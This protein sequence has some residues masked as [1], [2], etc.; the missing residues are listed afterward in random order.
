MSDEIEITSQ[1]LQKIL[2]TALE[3]L[4]AGKI[5]KATADRITDSAKLVIGA[6]R[7]R[8]E[9]EPG[10]ERRKREVSLAVG[11]LREAEEKL[12]RLS[13]PTVSSAA[14]PFETR[15]FVDVFDSAYVKSQA[16]EGRKLIRNRYDV[17]RGRQGGAGIVCAPRTGVAIRVRV[18]VP[19]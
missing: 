3:C 18:T 4:T 16:H 7:S 6:M 13:K 17:L 11:V 19:G 5:N 1:E 2:L 8:Q 14:Q 12:A 9:S 15:F 10:Q